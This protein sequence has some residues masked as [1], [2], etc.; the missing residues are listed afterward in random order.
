VQVWKEQ[1]YYT[2]SLK[3][4]SSAK[5]DKKDNQDYNNNIFEINNEST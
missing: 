1:L 2:Q 4:D 3:T 5:Y